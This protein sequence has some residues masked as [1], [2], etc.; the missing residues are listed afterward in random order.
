MEVVLIILLALL[1]DYLLGEPRV[2]HPLVYF[3]KLADRLEGEHS[4]NPILPKTRIT[5]SPFFL[6]GEVRVLLHQSLGE[7]TLPFLARL[8]NSRIDLHAFHAAAGR[9]FLEN[10]AA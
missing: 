1:A 7:G 8:P 3:G 4:F 2:W 6:D 5:Q 9:V 10:V